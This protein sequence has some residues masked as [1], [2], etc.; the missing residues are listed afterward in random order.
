[1]AVTVALGLYGN[2]PAVFFNLHTVSKSLAEFYTL[3]GAFMGLWSH[4]PLVNL[5]LATK[6]IKYNI[7]VPKPQEGSVDLSGKKK[8]LKLLTSIR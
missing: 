5:V 1:M 7:N 6:K 4:A 3:I 8:I 2:K